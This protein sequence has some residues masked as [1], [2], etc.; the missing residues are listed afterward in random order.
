MSSLRAQQLKGSRYVRRGTFYVP[1]VLHLH[2]L[3][4]VRTPER[5]RLCACE[6]PPYIRSLC[7]LY[8]PMAK[9]VDLGGMVDQVGKQ[10]DSETTRLRCT[11]QGTVCTRT[12]SNGIVPN[13]TFL[14]YL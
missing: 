12:C 3:N 8:E 4:A 10:Q 13:A 14:S 6:W 2:T 11:R 5:R 1:Y 7:T 9:W